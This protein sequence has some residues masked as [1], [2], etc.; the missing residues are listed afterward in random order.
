MNQTLRIPP[1]SRWTLATLV[2]APVI[3]PIGA[4]ADDAATFNKSLKYTEEVIAKHHL[5]A[6]VEIEPLDDGKE[7]KFRY[8]R[9]PEVERV[10]LGKISYVRKKGKTWV[11]SDDW[12]DTSKKIKAAK[13]TELDA[14]VSFADAPL[15]NR[16][17]AK[18]KAQGGF[19][20]ELTK[21][22]AAGT[23]ERLFYEVRR[24][25]S[26][27]FVYPQFVFTPWKAGNDENALLI[28]YG[29][30]MYSGEKK[31]R[32]NINYEYMFLV[33]LVEAKDDAKPKNGGAEKPANQEPAPAKPAKA[34]PAGSSATEPEKV[35]TFAEIARQRAALKNQVVKVEITSEDAVSKKMPNG[36]TR[37]M[38]RD[39][40]EPHSF[41]GLV[42]FPTETF[43][44]LGLTDDSAK[45]ALTIYVRVHEA[46]KDKDAP[47]QTAMG[48][49]A[50]KGEDG[51]TAYAW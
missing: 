12:G 39:T 42:D 35:Y 17:V 19:V 3:D 24:E 22:E 30:L 36:I 46:S 14:L 23:S 51:G 8:D 9:Y 26:T 7:T 37:A 49:K 4:L 28:G 41:I 38:V 27:G 44:K 5:I 45:K 20:V 6:L 29:G 18:D 11:Q 50:V 25:N 40:A 15:K 10:Q 21:R 33:N 31:V 43:N 32:V 16:I 13:A 2:L 34:E 1:G 48:R 47:Q